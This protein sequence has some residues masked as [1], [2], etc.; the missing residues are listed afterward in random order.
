MRLSLIQVISMAVLCTITS[1]YDARC[2]SECQGNVSLIVYC[3][4][5]VFISESLPK[6]VIVSVCH[7]DQL[8]LLCHTT[9]NE[10]LLQWTLIIP[11]PDRPGPD[12]R[13]ISSSG[14]T[15][16]VTPLVVGQTVFQFLRISVSP[17]EST[18]VINNASTRVN[19]TRVECSYGGEVMETTI[20]SVIG[21]GTSKI[22]VRN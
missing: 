14:S 19:G 8:T 22:L 5:T 21:N 1:I 20:I 12:N 7:G 2:S 15:A 16:S 13:F 6:V 3:N 10:T 18:L 17:L 11:I 4:F 9:P